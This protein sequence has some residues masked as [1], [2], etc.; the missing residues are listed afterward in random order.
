VSVS[1]KRSVPLCL[2]AAATLKTVKDRS[3]ERLRPRPIPTDTD[4]GTD[5]PRSGRKENS[6]RINYDNENDS[7]RRAP[8]DTGTDTDTVLLCTS[9]V[10][11]R[12][13]KAAGAQSRPPGSSRHAGDPAGC[14]SRER[15]DR[16]VRWFGECRYQGSRF[17][18]SHFAGLQRRN[19]RAPGR[20]VI[21]D[22]PQH[23]RSRGRTG[24]IF[25]GAI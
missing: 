2:F 3:R 7:A 25:T 22:R 20:A 1:G 23:L 19:V 14:T 21:S 8:T 6:E 17:W 24:Q 9:S 5:T 13:F 16:L 15:M 12:V 11:F 4:T 10:L 18:L